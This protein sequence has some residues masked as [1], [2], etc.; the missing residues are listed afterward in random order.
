MALKDAGSVAV[1]LPGAFY[2][3]RE[4][5]EPPIDLLRQHGVPMAVATDCNPGSSPVTSLLLSMNM[6]CT[7][8]RMTPQE[9]LTGVTRH[10]ARALGL[11]DVGTIEV[12]KTAELAV[13]DVTQPAELCYRIGFNPL[14]KRITGGSS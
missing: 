3:L 5:Q 11:S 14:V 1:M 4:T 13:W 10:A 6:A 7:L 9:A 8:F 2:T 12:G